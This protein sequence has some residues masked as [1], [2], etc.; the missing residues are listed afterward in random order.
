MRPAPTLSAGALCGDSLHRNATRT[1]RLPKLKRNAKPADM[2]V[3]CC[4]SS[5]AAPQCIQHC[6]QSTSLFTRARHKLLLLEQ[7]I[8]KLLRIKRQQVASLLAHAH[9]AYGQ[10]EIPRDC[11]HY[12]ALCRAVELR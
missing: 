8:H 11:D 7:R 1:A 5:Y 9:K 4:I 2:T 12:A 6:A 3:P 10:T